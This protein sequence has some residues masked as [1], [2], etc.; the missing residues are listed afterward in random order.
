M[1]S[2][3]FVTQNAAWTNR[4]G[5]SG[6]RK[7][8]DS[9]TEA[10]R[11]PHGLPSGALLWKRRARL[12]DCVEPATRHT[13]RGLGSLK[14]SRVRASTRRAP[15]STARAAAMRTFVPKQ[16]SRDSAYSVLPHCH[17]KEQLL[18]SKNMHEVFSLE[19]QRL[20]PKIT[21]DTR[22]RVKRVVQPRHEMMTRVWPI[23]RRRYT[24]CTAGSS[25]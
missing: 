24:T 21:Q 18:C 19:L 10:P 4:L 2:R 7:T 22:T 20:H 16:F 6:T 3:Q 8:S 5:V 11:R 14:I 12:H 13:R 1:P 15:R 23:P 25:C 9:Q 17:D